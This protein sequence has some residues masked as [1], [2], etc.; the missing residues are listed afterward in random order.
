MKKCYILIKELPVITFYSPS[1]IVGIFDGQAQ[2]ELKQGELTPVVIDNIITTLRLRIPHLRRKEYIF[3]I[4]TSGF[5]DEGINLIEISFN[6]NWYWRLSKFSEIFLPVVILLICLNISSG[7]KYSDYITIFI[8]IIA[9]LFFI[10]LLI[11]IF[12]THQLE[13]KLRS[14]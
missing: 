11:K 3:T 7:E 2:I 14:I 9:A 6:R 10:D 5:K 12:K 13:L 1:R 4:D 8:T